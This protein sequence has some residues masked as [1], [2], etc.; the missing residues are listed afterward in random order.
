MKFYIGQLVRI[1]MFKIRPTHWNF[2]GKMDEL[3]GEKVTVSS[4]SN[5]GITDRL[6]VKENVWCWKESDFE[7]EDGL[8][9]DSLFE[10]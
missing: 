9:E 3:M 1:K 4:S 6:F 7:T 5:F 2:Q 8:L 10:I